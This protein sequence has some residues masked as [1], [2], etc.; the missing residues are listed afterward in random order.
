MAVKKV[1][2]V[3]MG[4]RDGLQNEKVVLST[5]ARLE[6]L[7]KLLDIGA[8]RIEIGAFV[9]PQWVPQMAGSAEV[10]KAALELQKSKKIPKGTEFSVLVPNEKGMLMA[11]ESGIK[12]VAIF[13]AASESFSKKNINCTIEESFERFKP[14]MALA[15]KHKIK[16]RGYLSTCFGCPFEGKVSEAKVIQLAKRLHQIGCY[17]ISIGDTIGV[18]DPMQVE[19]IFKKLKKVVPVKKLAAHFHDTRGTALANILEAYQLGVR[20]FDASV[21]G[22]GGCPYAPGAAGNVSTE[23]VAYMF[24][25]MGVKT[26]LD[27]EKMVAMNP[28]LTEK[29]QHTLPTKVG[30][31]GFLKPLGKI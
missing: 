14:V 24:H 20:V 17:E 4:L 25:G 28:W 27:I 1:T 18:A 29:I 6:I 21:G 7:Q 8:R 9:S 26:G 12:E 10:T 13:A 15:K 22:L 30:K 11:I 23:D 31:V 5:Q 2:I 16:V 3:E 19:R